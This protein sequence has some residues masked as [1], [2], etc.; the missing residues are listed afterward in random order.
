MRRARNRPNDRR[1][2]PIPDHVTT[3]ENRT[4]ARKC[5]HGSTSITKQIRAMVRKCFHGSTSITKEI[6][7]TAR[8]CFH[9]SISIT[10]QIRA[11][12]RICFHCITS[13]LKELGQRPAK[14]LTFD[15]D[16]QARSYTDR[17]TSNPG[18]CLA[19]CVQRL[20]KVAQ[21]ISG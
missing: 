21:Y 18:S 19:E 3:K 1:R 9:G 10:K 6:R 7:A 4:A 17:P 11:T 12:A 8:K 2:I 14:S 15:T 5:F 20:N 13:A 16:R